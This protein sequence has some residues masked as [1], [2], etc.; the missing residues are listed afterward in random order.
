MYMGVMLGMKS[1]DIVGYEFMGVVE[2]VGFEVK[3]I[4]EGEL[5][6][7]FRLLLN[8]IYILV[9]SCGLIIGLMIW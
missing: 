1:G 7:Y 8:F 9:V 3:D 6:L 4:K 5:S 2:V